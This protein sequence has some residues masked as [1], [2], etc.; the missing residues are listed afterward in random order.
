MNKEHQTNEVR[1]KGIER[2]IVKHEDD[3]VPWKPTA[4]TDMGV[5]YEAVRRDLLD[6]FLAK[7]TPK[8]YDPTWSRDQIEVAL[9]IVNEVLSLL[10]HRQHGWYCIYC[11]WL[12]FQEVVSAVE[13]WS[14]ERCCKCGSVLPA[15]EESLVHVRKM[16]QGVLSTLKEEDEQLS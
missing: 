11:G 15:G 9:I 14:D 13:G 1:R 6:A 5:Y 4:N 10:V 2:L 16:G 8:N 12:H 3:V 7:H